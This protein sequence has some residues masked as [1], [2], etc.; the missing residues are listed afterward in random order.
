MTHTN[1]SGAEKKMASQWTRANSA[2]K[3][4]PHTRI[5]DESDIQVKSLLIYMQ[6][7]PI[8]TCTFP[9]SFCSCCTEYIILLA[10]RSLW[11]QISGKKALHQGHGL[12]RPN[13]T[14]LQSGSAFFRP[15]G[16]LHLFM[17]LIALALSRGFWLLSLPNPQQAVLSLACAE[18]M[19]KLIRPEIEW[20]AA[21]T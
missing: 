20:T 19:I 21:A 16:K 9:T 4:V 2:E 1:V 10:I 14:S 12:A 5:E 15:G 6:C 3:K 18:I 13:M 17:L 11:L 7:M 8:S